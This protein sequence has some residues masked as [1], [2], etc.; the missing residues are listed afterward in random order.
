[1]ILEGIASNRRNLFWTFTHVGLGFV[2]TLTPFALVVW[3]YFIF[4]T[5]FFK[6]ISLL[7]KQKLAFF[8]M[9]FSYLIS[10]ELLDR[11]ANTSPFIPYELGKY[12]LV[13][14]GILGLN[15]MG[16]RSPRGI[17]M[18]LLLIP[19]LFLSV[20]NERDMKDIISN[21]IGP[22]AVS[23]GVA[24]SNGAAITSNNFNQILKLIWLPCLAS[25]AYTYIQTPD[26]DDITFSLKANF[27][28]T[29]GHSSNQVSTILGLGVFLSFYSGLNNLKFSGNRILDFIIMGGF[30][31]QG[32]LSFSRG[33]M[34]IGV[35]G[36]VLLVFLSP[37]A[38]SNSR[39]R[40]ISISLVF[41]SFLFLLGA[42]EIANNVTGGNLLLRYTG[43]SEG[44]IAG[45]KE[46]DLNHF[47]TGRLDIFE[48][49]VEL[50][51]NHFFLG[52]GVGDSRYL[53]TVMNGAPPHV[54]LSR[55][56][57]EHGLLGFIYALL[58]FALPFLVWRD[59]RRNPNSKVILVVLL[60]IAI[61]TSFHAAMRTF[62]TPLFMILG[63]L[64][65]I[66]SKKKYTF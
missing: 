37:V 55:L 40:N 20:S 65:I 41:V 46:K 18:F 1:M 12:F 17:F 66:E 14:L 58:W 28:T 7:Q 42:F 51:L 27:E 32:L 23:L 54:E 31:I 24:F 36:S 48:G 53:R 35:F 25:L 44:T 45:S 6:A 8:L 61:T 52:V 50:W 33:G 13:V 62:V 15:S 26:F 60:L 63:C 11:M 43:E 57:A 39:R 3:F 49:D 47:V 19:S 5:N 22:I 29:A 21:F 4:V 2:C 16:L 64:K 30:M 38:N 10:F 56:F 59:S 34:L 9:F